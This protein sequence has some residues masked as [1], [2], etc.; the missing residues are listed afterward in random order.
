LE[1]RVEDDSELGSLY[2]LTLEAEGY[3][4][5][6]AVNSIEAL[7]QVKDV[8]Q[9]WK[10]DTDLDAPFLHVPAHSTIPDSRYTPRIQWY[11]STLT[12]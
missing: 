12:V 9:G 6:R 2:Q 11:G 10:G 4:V 5:R 3:C 7:K 8:Q 1:G